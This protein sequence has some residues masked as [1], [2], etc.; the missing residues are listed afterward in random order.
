M[1]TRLEW[2]LLGKPLRWVVTNPASGET[3]TIKMKGC[4]YY[5]ALGIRAHLTDATFLAEDRWAELKE[6]SRPLAL[7]ANAYAKIRRPQ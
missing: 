1:H 4:T 5:H 3:L 2:Q 7:A 6:L